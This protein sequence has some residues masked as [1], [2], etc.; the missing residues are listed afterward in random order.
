MK[1]LGLIAA[2]M[3]F[4]AATFAQTT[5][6]ATTS[7]QTESTAKQG[8][9]AKLTPEENTKMKELDSCVRNYNREKAAA[10]RAMVKGDFK[11]S[12]A[13]YAIADADKKNMKAMAAQL[14]NEGVRRPL[15]LARKQIKKADNK[16]IM[17]DIKTVKAD[18]LAKQKALSAGDSTALKLA[19]NNLLADKNNL[20]KDIKDTSHDDT[21]HFAVIRPKS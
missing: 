10:K 2:A 21:K 18:K 20:K 1:K 19:E 9:N 8:D 17:A 15:M 12:K 5:T 7:A 3:F 11:T 13:D 14:K 4:A 6:S 16:M